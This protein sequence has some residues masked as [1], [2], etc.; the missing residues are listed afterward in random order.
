MPDGSDGDADCV[1]MARSRS[2]RQCID[3]RSEGGRNMKRNYV[4]AIVAASALMGLGS[5]AR[6]D[7]AIVVQVAPPAPMH[8]VIPAPRHGYTW[9]PG[10]YAYR[11]G[12]YVWLSGHW[13]PE[14]AG[15]VWREAHWRQR[16]D[17]SW[18]FVEGHWS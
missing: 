17:G 1:P 8:E 18:V 12:Q 5:A 9:A 16:D 2:G 3:I 7:S 4:F 13:M 6:A 14:R 11:D 15:Q 10:H